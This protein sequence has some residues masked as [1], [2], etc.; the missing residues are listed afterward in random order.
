M[1][2][3]DTM[4]DS[5]NLE[6]LDVFN[7]IKASIP[8]FKD[9]ESQ[10]QMI[11]AVVRTFK[12]VR[13]TD[14]TRPV[15]IIEAPTGTGKTMA[16]LTAAIPMARSL[17]KHLVV[18]TAS[19][20]L[21]EQLVNKDL[22]LIA[23]HAGI[24]I[25]YQLAKG[26]RRYVCANRL[27]RLG[28]TS[29]QASFWENQAEEDE[30]STITEMIDSYFNGWSGDRDS[31]NAEVS[32]DLWNK[33]STNSHGCLGR[34]C[35]DFNQCSFYIARG[36]LHQADVIVANH[37]LVL[38]DLQLGGG[39]ILS[40]PEDTLYI[41]D[42]AHHI[43][44]KALSHFS[45][46]ASVKG[47][48]TWLESLSKTIEDATN[49]LMKEN[50]QT[51]QDKASEAIASAIETLNQLNL[52]L[53]S[54][55]EL[56]VQNASEMSQV[57]W[58]F[59]QGMIPVELTNF[60][61]QLG[62]EIEH[63]LKIISRIKDVLDNA[64]E[65]A[66]IQ[67][68]LASDLKPALGFYTERLEN[69]GYVWQLMIA[70][71][72]EGTPPIAR[73]INVAEDDFYVSASPITVD[74]ELNKQL[75][76]RCAA[77]ILTSATLSS[78]G[79]FNHLMERLGLTEHT[80]TTCMQLSSPFDYQN[81]AKLVIPKMG[82]IP[83]QFLQHTDEIIQLIP[84]LLSENE[85][86]L[87]LFSSW[88]QMNA[89]VEELDQEWKKKLIIQGDYSKQ[90]MLEIHH[91]RISNKQGSVLFGLASF[92]EGIDLPGELCTHVIIVKIPFSVPNTPIDATYAEWLEECGRNPFMEVSVPQASIRLKQAVGRLLR[93]ENDWGQVSILDRR[94]VDNR[95]GAVL[96]RS[97]PP[98]KLVV[99]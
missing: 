92:A 7:N 99:E 41:F 54:M 26:R 51:I 1:K 50:S 35:K 65:D 82:S 42:E 81:R 55:P 43:P 53:A 6:I 10:K 56:D 47:V 94:L 34:R 24:N 36:N 61:R 14:E 40:V 9:R 96:L 21:Q 77:S 78:G 60:G 49:I 29:N 27:K 23:K 74:E 16:Y 18:S 28:Q 30:K 90:K 19:V 12:Q 39:A 87:V 89:V 11:N 20:A 13:E 38:A 5:I 80:K 71:V 79:R 97:L 48:V 66:L 59:S 37:D 52:Y 63:L 72:K 84:N 75:W 45:A 3:V 2:F 15:A 25:T 62:P 57:V 31:W 32:Q 58:R 68:S 95:Y 17:K 76:P 98:M 86:G 64:L 4:A 83:K 46:T 93:S 73:W 44:D 33:I 22:P 88:K 67:D 69:L 91:Q 8:N 70:Q 85:G